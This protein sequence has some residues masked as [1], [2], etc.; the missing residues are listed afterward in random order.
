MKFTKVDKIG[1]MVSCPI[2]AFIGI[3]FAAM[4]YVGGIAL[5][6]FGFTNLLLGIFMPEDSKEE[7]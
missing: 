7:D 1:L 5:I 2:F 6:V 3:P 4:G